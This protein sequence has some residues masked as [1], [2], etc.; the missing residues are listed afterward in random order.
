MDND[1]TLNDANYGDLKIQPGTE[2][3]PD[4]GYRSWINKKTETA[5]IGLLFC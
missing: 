4:Y 1:R 2:K 3:Q 5:R